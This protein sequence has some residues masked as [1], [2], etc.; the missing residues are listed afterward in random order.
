MK[1]DDDSK[2]QQ[3]E[4]FEVFEYSFTEEEDDIEP[5]PPGNI[6]PFK[7]ITEW[8]SYICKIEKPAKA[9]AIYNFTVFEEGDE[10]TL[11]L[12]GRNS[13]KSSKD[14]HATRIEFAPQGMYFPLA[15]G[16]YKD[17]GREEV[18]ARIIFELMKFTNTETFASSLLVKANSITTDW[19]GEIWSK[20]Q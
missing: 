2:L 11:C 3:E 5:P 17:L 8:L 20:P 4:E 19:S 10:Y 7:S 12:T 15:V 16:E 1:L 13:Y 18:F 14:H 6:S 9:I